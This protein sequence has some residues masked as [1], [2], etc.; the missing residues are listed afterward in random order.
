MYSLEW[1]ISLF[2]GVFL[3]SRGFMQLGDQD[4]GPVWE[5]AKVDVASPLN[6]VISISSEQC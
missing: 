3:N 6:I 1:A 4:R 2:Y 5:P